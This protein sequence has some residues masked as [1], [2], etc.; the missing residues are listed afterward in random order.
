MSD[1]GVAPTE[2]TVS[3]AELV[4]LQEQL[5]AMRA[6]RDRQAFEKSE[7]VA[8]A[9]AYAKERD[10]LRARLDDAMAERDRLANDRAA[11]AAEKNEA[12]KRAEEA[13]AVAERLKSEVA[14]LQ[15]A[16]DT[17]PSAEPLTVLWALTTKYV[18]IAHDWLRA[19]IPA[20]S[21]ALPWFDKA[22]AF[23]LEAGCM[24][25]KLGKEFIAWATPKAIE[26]FNKGKAE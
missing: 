8:K 15:H 12:V 16:L 17:A 2:E 19:K 13:A 23:S 10:E 3:R 5:K 4:N 22:V 25:V 20:D 24:A 26:L 6:E 14:R 18:K 9:N 7:I 1:D 21:A 11:A